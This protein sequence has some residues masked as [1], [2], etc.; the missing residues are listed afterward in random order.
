MKKTLSIIAVTCL[1]LISVGCNE[2]KKV[3]NTA[4]SVTLDG[5]YLINTID[6]K[7]NKANAL[8]LNFNA[9]NKMVSGNAGCN[10]F[11]GSY[12]I[13]IFALSVGVLTATEAFCEE[14]TMSL[15]Q[16]YFNALKNTGSYGI[17]DDVLTLY[18]KTDRSPILTAKK[19]N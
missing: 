14:P 9:L 16:S 10:E 8:T 15:E 19:A 3:I 1:M 17:K 7:T 18:S 5:A 11:S 4:S 13:D 12:S 6:G 2:T